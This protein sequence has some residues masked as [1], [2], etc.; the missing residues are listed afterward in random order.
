MG[1]LSVSAGFVI[2]VGCRT[3]A[4]G[5]WLPKFGAR[6]SGMAEGGLAV[7]LL[8]QTG[9]CPASKGGGARSKLGSAGG[10]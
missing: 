1:G 9:F 2:F 3:P 7:V 10:W 8:G 5:A 6:V 4:S